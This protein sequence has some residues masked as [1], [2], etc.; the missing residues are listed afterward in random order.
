LKLALP[1]LA[2]CLSLSLLMPIAALG[3]NDATD[4]KLDRG[5]NALADVLERLTPS[6]DTEDPP[7]GAQVHATIE[8]LLQ[9]DRAQ[10][11]L[12][13]IEQRQAVLAN[14]VEPGQDVQLMFLKGRALA[15]L[16]R[17]Q[18]AQLLYRDMTLRY[19]ELAEPWNNLAILY[20]SRNDYDQALLALETAVMNNP[21]Y[22]DALSNLAHLR[23]LMAVRDYERAASLGD[24]AAVQ[25][26]SALRQFIQEVNQP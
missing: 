2:T 16:G 22:A 21:R 14:Q 19:P 13:A 26:A 25:R 7:S 8:N 3:Q 6:F 11:A 15:Q 9:R 17:T 20:I 24:R 5:W 18:D 23:L 12:E 4:P 1:L 10:A